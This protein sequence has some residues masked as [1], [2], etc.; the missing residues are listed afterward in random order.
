MASLIS[1]FPL[2]ILILI[3]GCFTLPIDNEHISSS[4][5]SS[6]NTDLTTERIFNLRA[7]DDETSA[8]PNVEIK[9]PSEKNNEYEMSTTVDGLKEENA[10]RPPRTFEKFSNSEPLTITTEQSHTDLL[11]STVESITQT[12][13]FEPRNIKTGLD[14]ESELSDDMDPREMQVE[15]TTDDLPSF[16]SAPSTVSG[17]FD[18]SKSSTSTKKHI[19]FLKDEDEQQSE[20][21]LKTPSKT[22]VKQSKIQSKD[23][24]EEDSTAPIAVL[25]QEALKKVA[26]V[27]NDFLVLDENNDFVVTNLPNKFLTTTM[28]NKQEEKALN[29]GKKIVIH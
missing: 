29:Q 17:G 9:Q 23:K 5:F 18:K 26:N 15:F 21:F 4:T 25:D 12:S 20:K 8:L 13:E 22:L 11:F 6:L 10:F 24:Y 16:T 14:T 1:T 19:R 7:S 3:N 2:F 28:E 27:P